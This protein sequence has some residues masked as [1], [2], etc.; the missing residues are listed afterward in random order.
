MA[1]AKEKTNAKAAANKKT[2]RQGQ[3]P[4]TER[5][6]IEDLTDAAEALRLAKSE[7]KGL[8][9]K[10]ADAK[11]HLEATVQRHIDD[12]TIKLPEKFTIK[13]EPIY[14]YE[15]EDGKLQSVK[16][17][18]NSKGDVSIHDGPTGNEN[19]GDE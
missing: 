17:T 7:R 18:I 15:D 19:G 1:K 13:K 14:I 4:G 9:A 3:I 10:V 16:W 6:E 2:R 8:Q 12:G 11:A 5:D